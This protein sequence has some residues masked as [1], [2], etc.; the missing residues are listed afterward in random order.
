MSGPE[1]PPFPELIDNTM[2]GSFVKC[3]KLFYWAHHRQLA[4]VAPS[5]HLH[6][7]GA[8][9]FGL[10]QARRAFF[11]AE[12]GVE[13]SIRK[14]LEG[15]ISFYGPIQLPPARNGDKSV[16]NVIRAFDSYMQKYPLDRDP[17]Q[18]FKTKSGQYMIE[19]K[20]AI[21]TEIKH[22]V[23]GNPILYG[24]RSDMIGM[25]NGA[26]FV[27]DEKTATSLGE[28]WA[29]Q[30][31][32][33]SQFT[34][35][36]HAAKHY[37]YPVAGALIR[38]VGMLKTKITHAEAIVMRSD[39]EIERWWNQLHR[40]IKRMKERW[41]EGYW[42]YA[43]SKDACQ[44][45]GGCTFKLLCQSPAPN[46]W[47]PVHYRHHV[48]DPMAK[49]LGEKLLENEVAMARLTAPELDIPDLFPQVK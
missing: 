30:W 4:G 13:E 23:T 27:T 17:I 41:E 5:I 24:G 12:A 37:G 46:D 44:S 19:F 2:R 32:L 42:D 47:I 9:A 21:P 48:W 18:A 22:P 40:N 15:I 10:E 39:W 8:F 14:G 16:E 49:D 6:A 3:E 1:R 11:E 43:L 25:L 20:F 28:Q 31:D 38:G 29:A 26:L 36:I 33:E 34:G 45:F 35:Y 7:G